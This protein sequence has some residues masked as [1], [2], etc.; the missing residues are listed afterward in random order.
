MLRRALLCAAVT[1]ALCIQWG[2]VLAASFG[3]LVAALVAGASMA[4]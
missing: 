2:D 1:F 4:R 3:A